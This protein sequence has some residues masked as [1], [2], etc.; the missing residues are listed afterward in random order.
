[1]T[2]AKPG[3][4]FAAP[5]A[6]TII[7]TSGSIPTTQH[8][9]PASDQGAIISAKGG[10]DLEFVVQPVDRALYHVNADNAFPYRLCGGQQDSGSVCMASRG[11]DGEIT[12]RDWHPVDAKNTAT[13]AP[14][15][16]IRT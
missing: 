5:L 14:I 9:R 16:S 1:M 6:A 7:R 12:L 8:H 2:A 15:R 11:N 3:P 4:A 13:C 10:A